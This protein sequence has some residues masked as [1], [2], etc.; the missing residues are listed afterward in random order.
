MKVFI[1]EAARTPFG[2]YFGA[3]SNIRPDDL[4]GATIRELVAKTPSLN[5]NKIDDVV[6]GDANGAGED[7][8][9]VAR[10]GALLAGLPETVPGVT[11]NRLCGSG[12]EAVIQG[13]RAIK[14][15]DAKFLIAG[16]VESMSRAPWIVRRTE[17]K[18]PEKVEIGELNQSTVGWRMTNPNF[19][20]N[21][22]E[23]LGRCSEKVA[24]KLG[25]S[26]VEQ[27]E[28]AL[29]S[30]QLADR[31]W[32]SKFHDGFVFPFGGL[33]RDESIRTDTSL[34]KLADLPS[35]FSEGGTGTAGNSSPINDGA[36]TMLL[37]D[38]SGI[39]DLAIDSKLS[40]G[41]GEILGSKVVA[42]SPDEFSLAPV[43]AINGLLSKLSLSFKDIEI[44]EIN[45]AFASMVL[46]VLKEL[47][48]IDRNRVN[49]NGG[50][51]AI[52]HP[53]GGSAARVIVDTTRELRRRGGG[54]G[55][56]AACIGVGLGVAIAIRV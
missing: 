56:A 16:G 6:I 28:W 1:A 50:A 49:V 46:T 41:F 53:V 15:G 37:T 48:E 17:K 3:L 45:E 22:T 8:R 43:D 12:A 29:R 9:N 55:I 14:T 11:I 35:A 19:P 20:G 27:D 26:R 13:S 36:V 47:P 34:A 31:A 30:H 24:A 32:N 2:A 40:G 25:I 51:I 42:R 21:W 23:S 18:L 4:L 52:G 38:E 10:M 44:W 54:I 39:K 7:N 33:T 5:K